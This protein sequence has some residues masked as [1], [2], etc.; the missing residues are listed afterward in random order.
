MFRLTYKYIRPRT[1][2]DVVY[3][4]TKYGILLSP[5]DGLMY[6]SRNMSHYS[7]VQLYN[8]TRGRD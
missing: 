7:H 2:V 3:L 5:E 6:L 8:T 1:M 4:I